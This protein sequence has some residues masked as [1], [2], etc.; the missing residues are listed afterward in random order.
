MKDKSN[1]LK[2][3][4]DSLVNNIFKILPLYEEKNQ[5]VS[6]YVDSLLFE[7][8]GL[9]DLIDIEVSSE[10]ISLINTLKSIKKEIDSNS[11]EHKVIKRE[12]FKSIG[13]LKNITS[14]LKD[15]WYEKLFTK[16]WKKNA[17]YW[18]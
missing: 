8:N 3:Y 12:V 15:D 9:E 2:N 7:I 6:T 10:Y 18:R 1:I 13:I 14:K 4:F 16:V 17:I 11:S 5:G